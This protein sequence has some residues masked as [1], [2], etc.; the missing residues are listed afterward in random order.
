MNRVS[1]THLRAMAELE[2]LK[3][4]IRIAQRRLDSITDWIPADPL[5]R[6]SGK[7]LG[8]VNNLESRIG[9]KL[10]VTLIGPSG[11]GKSTL[12][13]ALAG[14][15][16]LASI[17]IDRPTTSRPLVVG[18][19]HADVSQL[20]ESLGKDNLDIQMA[21]K[22]GAVENIVLIDTPDTDSV[23]QPRHLPIIQQAVSLS[24]V[25]LCVF[26]AE[27]P[28]RLDHADLL[29]TL[30]RYFDGDSI[31]AVLNKCDRQSES[32]LRKSIGPD[33][34]KYLEHAWARPIT[35]LF[36]VSARSHLND[37]A[38]AATA[39]PRHDFD[40]FISLQRLLFEK[41][42]H[43]SAVMDRRLDN[44]RQLRNFL[45]TTI[46][47]EVNKDKETIQAAARRM[48]QLEKEAMENTLA[49]LQDHDPRRM[50]GVMVD[51]YAKLAQ[52]WLGPVGWLI[53]AWA[54]WLMISSGLGRIF[55]YGRPI[56]RLT[57][58]AASL[59][60]LRRSED[61]EVDRAPASIPLQAYRNIVLR[62][63]T[64]VAELLVRARFD[65]AIRNDNDPAVIG[66]QAGEALATLRQES[67]EAEIEASARRWSNLALQL[68][69]NLPVL[70]ALV[71]VGWI[72]AAEYL[73]GN[74]LPVNFFVHALV[75]LTILLFLC[76]FLFQGL[77]RLFAG[78]KRIYARAIKRCGRLAADYRPLT[79]GT[80]AG[81]IATLFDLSPPP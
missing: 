52:R 70:A 27:N 20:V 7:I 6:L 31:V 33:F 36:C 67:L 48:R 3:N 62:N 39:Q 44:A 2:H 46:Q 21:P 4:D 80:L 74:Y 30:V 55:R 24:D 23:E 18:T 41:L 40:E 68:L 15:D 54:R 12:I 28:K 57:G 35:H 75:T 47:T 11:S 77:L 81:Q 59:K 1:D 42:G 64:E 45:S 29:A 43:P 56:Q 58:L 8:I 49:G 65:P 37:P 63:W 25:L 73:T 71:H 19:A 10:V 61:S 16:D 60:H 38:W 32:E 34:Q 22:S 14:A 50:P 26:D 9:R 51:L 66:N 69:L 78:R 72:T 79:T 5:A 13:N 17:G 53:A 76:F